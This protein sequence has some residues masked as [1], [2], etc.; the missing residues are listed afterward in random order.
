MMHKRGIGKRGFSEIGS[1]V[2]RWQEKNNV[3]IQLANIVHI[4]NPYSV[5]IEYTPNVTGIREFSNDVGTETSI[6][7]DSS[8][9]EPAQ[10]SL[11]F[12]KDTALALGPLVI[13]KAPVDIVTFI[14]NNN[15]I[16]EYALEK[17]ADITGLGKVTVKFD[18]KTSGRM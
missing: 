6:P 4:N 8:R 11:I 9:L 16:L 12:A 17:P 14:V 7:S 10:P 1:L 15:N 2:C 3:V 18:G 13:S 5:N